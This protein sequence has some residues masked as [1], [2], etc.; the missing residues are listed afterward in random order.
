MASDPRPA[1]PPV[2]YLDFDGV[3]HREDVYRHPK[4]G[5]YL[6]LK[7]ARHAL[8]EHAGLLEELLQPYPDVGIV[9]WT[10]WVRVLSFSKARCRL[11]VALSERVVGATFHSSMTMRRFKASAAGPGVEVQKDGHTAESIRDMLADAA[12]DDPPPA[13][14]LLAKAKN[15]QREKWDWALQQALPYRTYASL[16]LN[17]EEAL[18]WA[19]VSVAGVLDLPALQQPTPHPELQAPLDMHVESQGAPHGPQHNNQLQETGT[20]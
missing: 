18:P 16:C 2:L 6:G 4:R 15:L 5:I 9:L 3:L 20:P 17:L 12:L 7:G 8:F 1:S 10:S 14:V 11:P 19:K 13:E